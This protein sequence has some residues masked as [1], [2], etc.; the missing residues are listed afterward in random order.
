MEPSPTLGNTSSKLFGIGFFV[1]MTGF[2]FYK[3]ITSAARPMSS[4]NSSSLEALVYCAASWLFVVGG[5]FVV[6]NTGSTTGVIVGGC[7][8]LFFGLGGIV[9][10][11]RAREDWRRR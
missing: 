1:G 7:A 10:L 3:A 5:V 11:R 8:I 2:A 6:L 9:L 4:L